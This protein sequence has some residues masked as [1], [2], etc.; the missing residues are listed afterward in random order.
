[1]DS[2]GEFVLGSGK[3]YLL[4]LVLL[5]IILNSLDKYKVM[6]MNAPKN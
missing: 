2:L 5:S 1:M 3:M 6:D 4:L